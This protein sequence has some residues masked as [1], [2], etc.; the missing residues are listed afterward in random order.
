MG[1]GDAAANSTIVYTT[2]NLGNYLTQGFQTLWENKQLFD[3]TIVIDGRKFELH[4]G[5]LIAL[6]PYFQSM[7]TSGFEEAGKSKVE[8]KGITASG[9]SSVVN[10]LYTSRIS[11]NEDTLQDTMEAGAHLQIP[12]VIDFCGQFIQ[13]RLTTSN[14]FE[15]LRLVFV[16]D[17]VPSQKAIMAFLAKHCHFMKEK[18][19]FWVLPS[20]MMAWVLGTIDLPFK[21]E[22]EVLKVAVEWLNHNPDCSQEDVMRVFCQVR[23]AV[24]SQEEITTQLNNVNDN[25]LKDNSEL[26]ALIQGA[27][28]YEKDLV[29]LPNMQPKAQFRPAQFD[30]QAVF[31][32]QEPSVEGLSRKVSLFKKDRGVLQSVEVLHSIPGSIKDCAACLVD[33]FVF[34]TGGEEEVRPIQGYKAVSTTHRFDFLSRRWVQMADMNEA[35]GLHGVA[36]IGL[37]EMMVIGGVP[38]YDERPGQFTQSAEIYNIKENR[39]RRVRDFPFNVC[40][41]R[42]CS[43]NNIVYACGGTLDM[44]PRP[45]AN[46][47]RLHKYNY[48]TDEW[49]EKSAM[50]C[51]KQW[52]VMLECNSKIY[53]FGGVSTQDME[54]FHIA[55]APFLFAKIVESYNPGTNQWTLIDV[56]QHVQ[57]TI[58]RPIGGG[59]VLKNTMYLLGSRR[60][61]EF[62]TDSGSWH[63]HDCEQAAVGVLP[64][65]VKVPPT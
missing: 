56:P 7:F 15:F 64:V 44:E 27:R 12:G 46:S 51:K 39:W 10:F 5:L 3:C 30:H 28:G 53:V 20:K 54:F 33:D 24:L 2:D 31:F 63:Q 19:E 62:N 41:I 42:A 38:R 14:C 6:S 9:F 37:E 4:K 26:Q 45:R 58:N 22:C 50:H 52:H 8:L 49:E 61:V 55:H 35:R 1:A 40:N 47:H 60:L 29:N 65:A 34:V 57:H 43:L 32:I 59:F 23:Y 25:I 16:Y 48:E 18:E 11:I 13:S 21:S 17:H 36:S